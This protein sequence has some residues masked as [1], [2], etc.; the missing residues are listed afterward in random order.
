MLMRLHDVPE[1]VMGICS[2]S[3][4]VQNVVEHN[5]TIKIHYK[6]CQYTT[7]G[8]QPNNILVLIVSRIKKALTLRD[9]I[10]HSLSQW[11][12]IEA[13]CN[14]CYGIGTLLKTTSMSARGKL[15]IKCEARSQGPK[16]RG[17]RFLVVEMHVDFVMIFD[18]HVDNCMVFVV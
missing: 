10:E 3:D 15:F 13:Q 12:S 5:L 4:V 6:A 16:F 9:I 14:S 17:P 18:V 8:G 7:T 1:F 11:H 2:K